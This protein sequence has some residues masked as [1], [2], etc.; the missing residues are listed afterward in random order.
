ML[1]SAKKAK[2]GAK[3]KPANPSPK[4]PG[5]PSSYSDAIATTICERIAAGESL[6]RICRDD[7]M[8][9]MST[10][11]RWLASN[12]EFATRYARAREQQAATYVDQMYDLADTEP[13]R[14][15]ITGAIDPASVTH[16]RN[17]IATMQWLAMKLAPKKFG[18]KL[19]VNHGGQEGNPIQAVL[20]Q[21]SG[22]SLP[23]VTDADEDAG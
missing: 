18:D 3:K 19:D 8:P 17:K 1:D 5:R 12:E 21:V 20:Q 10:V 7:N 11:I 23:V 13:E 2:G 9:N 14:H 6:R 22:T 15:P 4:K 16:I